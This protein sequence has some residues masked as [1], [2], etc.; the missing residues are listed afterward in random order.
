M[1]SFVIF[2]TLEQLYGIDIECVKRILPSPFLTAM[3][4]EEEHIEGM[5]KYEDE[6][7]KVLSFR[8][9]I[10]IKS[11]E[12]QLREM[13]PLLQAQHKEWLDALSE[14]LEKGV[15][16]TK[17][18]NPHSCS[19]GKWIDSFHPDDKELV[20]VMKHLTLHHQ[21]LH[22]SAVSLLEE[23][24]ANPE[25]A[26][27]RLQKDVKE[28]YKNTLKYLDD[29]SKMSEKVAATLQR[30]LILIGEQNRSFGI[31]IDE[32]VDILHIDEEQIHKAK[33]VQHMGD[34][35]NVAG[36]LEHKGK[37]ITIIKDVTINKRSA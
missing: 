20:E 7:I 30:C 27:N 6:I 31:N 35:M 34:F 25:A 36:I 19:L 4:D 37:L 33:E 14:S 2:K 1:T 3:P 23:R 22:Q 24:K 26:K 28:T 10:G 16:F 11:Y 5:F 32:V 12:K 13:F 29:V 17:T 18:T 9:V 15:P 21:R 8:K